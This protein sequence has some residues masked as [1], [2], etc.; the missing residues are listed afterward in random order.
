MTQRIPRTTVPSCKACGWAGTT[1]TP[2][3]AEYS[4]R[5]HS[6]DKHLAALAAAARG[7]A[8]AAAV[9][10]TPKPCRHKRADH[11]HGT[12][13]CYVLDACR[14]PPCSAA[15]TAYE[16]NRIRLHAYGRFEGFVDTAAARDHLRALSA[17]GMGWKRAAHVA[18][19]PES[20]VCP[21]LYGRKG[22]RGGAPRER[23]RRA[24]VEA[25]LAV[26]MPQLADL[27]AS[28]VVDST[29]TR[30]RVQ[31]LVVR[32][33]SVR[34]IASA[35]PQPFDRQPLDA[36]LAGR[37]VLARTALAVRAVYDEL[38][39]QAPPRSTPWE[40]A[41]VARSVR[42][43]G[44]AG[45]LPPLA[46]D[47]DTIDDPAVT[48]AREP[49]RRGPAVV[50]EVAVRRAIV[51]DDHTITITTSERWAAIAHLASQGLSDSAIADRVGTTAHT[52]LRV[53]QALHLESR[54]TA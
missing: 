22:R 12:H 13:A 54:Y 26:P 41:A 19:V 4:L 25:I 23:A 40:K 2:A 20:C 6:C 5:R 42:R 47:D 39:N 30:R 8:R 51:G 37:P 24:T 52:V 7:R 27:A 49:R 21:L 17:A 9:D 48:P 15:N 28:A 16:S 29:G 45:W 1:T 50:D 35:L 31:A 14:C 34:C 53:R 18:G 46:W 11:Q 32:G 10:R 33:W 3:K 44:A 38:W 36:A 43:A